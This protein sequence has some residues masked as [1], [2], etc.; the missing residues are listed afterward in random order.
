MSQMPNETSKDARVRVMGRLREIANLVT[1]NMSVNITM[2]TLET[3]LAVAE[4]E[5]LTITEYAKKLRTSMNTVSRQLLD[6]GDRG[7]PDKKTGQAKPGFKLVEPVIDPMDLRS[8]TYR[9]TPKGRNFVNSIV[10]I[11]ERGNGAPP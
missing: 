8:K 7:R 11:L 5:G 6:L 1:D 2:H 4:D 9:L 3:L 10:N